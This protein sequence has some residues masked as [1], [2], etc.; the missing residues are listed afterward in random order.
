MALQGAVSISSASTLTLTPSNSIY[1]YNGAAAATWTLPAVSG[2]SGEIIILYNRGAGTVTVQR[3]GSDQIDDGGAMVTSIPLSS[4]SSLELI[5]DGTYWLVMNG[6]GPLPTFDNMAA[7]TDKSGG[8]GAQSSGVAY[9]WTHTVG[10]GNPYGIVAIFSAD[11]AQTASGGP[12]ASTYMSSATVTFGGVTLS[13]LGYA[14]T[15]S[16]TTGGYVWLWGAPNIPSGS[17][18]VSVTLTKSGSTFAIWGNSFTYFNVAGPGAVLTE[19]GGNDSQPWSVVT[20]PRSSPNPALVFSAVEAWGNF[21]PGQAGFQLRQ[22]QY[23]LNQASYY[24]GDNKAFGLDPMN[25]VMASTS[26]NPPSWGAI[27]VELFGQLPSGPFLNT[28][29]QTPLNA[30]GTFLSNTL[31]HLAQLGSYV[32]VAVVYVKASGTTFSGVTYGGTAMTQL[33]SQFLNND[34]TGASGQ[35]MLYG[36]SNVTGGQQTITVNYSGA[37]NGIWA[38]SV[39]Y[40]NVH[41]VGTPATVYGGGSTLTQ[42]VTAA[43]NQMIFQVFGSKTQ[44][45][46]PTDSSTHLFNGGVGSVLG[47]LQINQAPATT[48]FTGTQGGSSP[49]AGIS[50]VLS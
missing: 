22:S 26:N 17:Q 37:P 38:D 45:I 8:F 42:S 44:S 43:A 32:F 6:S 12:A 5:N 14:S 21:S 30:G 39:S 31:Y 50:V 35:L 27:G 29:S 3:A 49:W 16:G 34:A 18:T 23:D 20:L 10:A 41:T 2:N 1:V 25:C 48:V 46:T 19:T 9:T 40:G 11:S 47:S 7:G 36:L 4:N 24:A 33:A 15:G 28:V 13:Q